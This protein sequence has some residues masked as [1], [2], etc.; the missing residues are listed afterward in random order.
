MGRRPEL[1][2]VEFSDAS[3][4]VFYDLD[5]ISIWVEIALR[6]CVQLLGFGVMRVRAAMP[7]PC[8]QLLVVGLAAGL[9]SH[10]ASTP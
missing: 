1:K 3:I 10:H 4:Q 9:H 6:L 2:S 7:E 5:E 8:P